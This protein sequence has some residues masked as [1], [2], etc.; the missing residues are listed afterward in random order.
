MFKSALFIAVFQ[1]VHNCNIFIRL[2]YLTLK[3]LYTKG[4]N[5]LYPPIIKIF[6]P[7]SI[8]WKMV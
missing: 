8:D 7:K 3:K 4:H 1:I 2:M 5:N 6:V